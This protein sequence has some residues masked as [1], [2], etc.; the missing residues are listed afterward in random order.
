[1]IYS[2]KHFDKPLLEFDVTAKYSDRYEITWVNEAEKDLLPLDMPDREAPTASGLVKWLRHRT[3]PK[4]RAYVFNLLSK[5][6]LSVNRTMDIIS[7][8]KGLSLNDCYWI[9]ESGFNGKFADYNLYDNRFSKALAMI[10][11]TGYGSTLRSAVMSSPEFTTNGMLPKCWRRI[12]GTV[13]LLKGGTV[14]ASNTGNEPYSE[15]YAYQI[16]KKLNINAVPYELHKW[17][18]VLCSSCELFTSEDYSF[19]PVGKLISADGIEQAIEYYEA[20]GP[21]FSKAISDMLLFDYLICNTDRHFGNFGVIIDNGTNKIIKPAPLFDHGNSLLNFAGSEDLSSEQ[22][23]IEYANTLTPATYISFYETAKQVLNHDYRVA[24]R[25][26]LDFRFT[27]H[28][29]YNLPPKRLKYL[30][31]VIQTRA[32]KLLDA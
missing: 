15:Y 1:M 21:E 28:S 32:K 2:L 20:L 16:A 5:C 12:N 7:V 23:L 11:F 19:V 31:K 25:S 13:S 8:S 18:G 24:L 17:K 29:R 22:S 26:L 3:I 4:N 27:R 30:E 14:G 9:T 6:G 10:A